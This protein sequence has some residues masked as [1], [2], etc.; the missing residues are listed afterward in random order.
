MLSRKVKLQLN[1]KQLSELKELSSKSAEIY[2]NLLQVNFDRLDAG[3]RMLT[4]FDMDRLCKDINLAPNI[5]TDVI[6]EI[7][8]R[9]DRVFKRWQESQQTKLKFWLQ[10]G[11][12]YLKPLKAYLAKAGK[13]LW[14][15][16]RFKTKGI[17]IQFPLRKTDQKRV[18]VFGNQT[19]V[20]VPLVGKVKGRNDRQDLIGLVKHVTVSKDSC[21]TW[22]ATIVC[23]GEAV[24]T[25]IVSRSKDIGV[26]LGLKHTITAA[27]E[28]EVIQPERER[29]I[30]KQIEAVRKAS[31]RNKQDLPFIHR[32]TARRRKH[33]H[34]VQA[35]RLLQAADTVIVGNLNSKFLFS[36]RLARSA[37]DAA[38]SQFLS[39]LAYKAANAGK[40][41]KIVNEAYTSQICYRCKRRQKMELSEREYHCP[42]G[43]SNNR[44]V[45]AAL[46][47]LSIG[48]ET[49]ASSS[50]QSLRL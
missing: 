45:N 50:E 30:D 6:Q 24:K 43:Y 13:K 10:H 11:E 44:D 27:N 23:D 34:H 2:N 31:R 25:E 32:K 20:N 37:S 48:R 18:K 36:G 17:S 21:N 35:K 38:H 3:Q 40:T 1:K 26:D 16:P 33:S 41:I 46:N 47:I 28:T 14:G 22:W 29:F 4:A 39:I 19:S 42:C 8:K 49:T 9:V 5:G 15:K 7:T 12:A